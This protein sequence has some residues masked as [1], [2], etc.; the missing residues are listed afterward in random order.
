MVSF[1]WNSIVIDCFILI[2]KHLN[3]KTNVLGKF[4]FKHKLRYEILKRVR[5][6]FEYVVS[7]IDEICKARKHIFILLWSFFVLMIFSCL[8]HTSRICEIHRKI[9]ICLYKRYTYILS[10]IK[11]FYNQS[12][13]KWFTNSKVWEFKIPFMCERTNIW[14]HVIFSNHTL[15]WVLRIFQ[16]SLLQG[17]FVQKRTFTFNNGS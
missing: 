5:S 6:M 3:V 16:L 13:V 1:S 2:R 8:G 10:A 4:D 9:K 11:A 7:A 14:L 12:K 17:R 15:K